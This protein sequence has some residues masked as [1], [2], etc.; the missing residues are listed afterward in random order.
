MLAVVVNNQGVITSV[1]GAVGQFG[2]SPDMVGSLW[3]EAFDGWGLNGFS[4]E[5]PSEA[6]TGEDAVS[7]TG[8]PVFVEYFHIPRLD[9]DGSNVAL[10]RAERGTILSAK[11]QQL[12]SLGEIAAGV[13][14]EINNALTL[15]NGWLD[16]L[17]AEVPEDDPQRPT[18]EMLLGEAERIGTLTRNLLEVA[19]HDG[20]EPKDLAIEPFLEEMLSLVS[21]DMKIARIEIERNIAADTPPIH[22]SPGRLKQALLN[23]LVNARQAMPGGGRVVISAEP[24][25][26]G[27]LRL[28]VEDTGCGMSP[29]VRRQIF[30]PFFT[31]K[32]GGTGLGLPLTKSI[33]EDLG[34]TVDIESRPG[35]STRFILR[36]PAASESVR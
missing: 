27:Y 33:I 31:T 3:A 32:E 22:A 17:L 13:G 34:G 30:N 26:E 7:P 18:L 4:F 10:F 29:E 35:E 16:L 12:C 21:Y 19:R 9:G 24:E 11:Q 36:I 1:T 14:H 6:P 8:E 28:T 5:N 25:E 20:E 23:L 2:T 15:L